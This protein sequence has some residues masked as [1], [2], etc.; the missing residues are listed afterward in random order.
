MKNI[1]ENIRA[2]GREHSVKWKDGDNIVETWTESRT[3]NV[4]KLREEKA[5]LESQIAPLTDEEYIAL[6]KA[7]HLT[8]FA[9]KRIDE[10]NA[11]L[12]QYG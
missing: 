6:G 10:I 3:I 12:E 8:E 9:L 5:L 4:V 1:S 2:I 11:E 7:S